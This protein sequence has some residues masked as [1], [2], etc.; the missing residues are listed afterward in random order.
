MTQ[1]TIVSLVLL[2][3]LFALVYY[4]LHSDSKSQ[5][6]KAN[7]YFLDSEDYYLMKNVVFLTFD[8]LQKF[9]YLIVSRFG[10]FVVMVQHY[11]GVIEG[12]EYE[13]NWAQRVRGKIKKQFTNP[14]DVINERVDT[15]CGLLALPKSQVFPIVLFDGIK[16]FKNE[17]SKKFTFGKHYS[18]YIHSKNK[19][20]FSA[21][22]IGKF[23][24]VIDAKRKRQGLVN[25]F[26]KKER[27]QQRI[28]PL[29]QENVCPECGS[30]VKI[31]AADENTSTSKQL[32]V[33]QLYPTCRFRREI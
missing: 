26:D 16:G 11:S 8:G 12:A 4:K 20:M 9:D 6:K 15:I 13:K 27:S 1:G 21:S 30:G 31:K 17:L 18:K 7:Q 5:I 25:D 24:A 19:L 10:I 28:A 33:C 14:T 3:A 2:S 22:Q 29:M 32:L 23:V